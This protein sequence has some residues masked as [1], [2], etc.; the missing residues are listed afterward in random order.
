VGN[1]LEDLH[2]TSMVGDTMRY[3]NSVED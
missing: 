1:A 3:S 2:S